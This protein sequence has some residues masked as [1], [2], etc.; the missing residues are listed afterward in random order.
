MHC[1][2]GGGEAIGSANANHKAPLEGVYGFFR[3]VRERAVK[4]AMRG[5]V[6]E[7]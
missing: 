1:K 7:E 2:W 3:K 4:E 6:R 5:R